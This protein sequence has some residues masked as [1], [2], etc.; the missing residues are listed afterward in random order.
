MLGIKIALYVVLSLMIILSLPLLASFMHN[1]GADNLFID[2]CKVI[3]LFHFIGDGVTSNLE[4][5]A[6]MIDIFKILN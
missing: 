2:F 5:F 6:K 1:A 4:K 3:D